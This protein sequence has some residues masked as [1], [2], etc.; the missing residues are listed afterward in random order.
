MGLEALLSS[1]VQESCAHL[2]LADELLRSI[3]EPFSEWSEA[4]RGRIR[5]SRA[6]IEGH[7][8]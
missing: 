8:T 3:A 2:Q 1:A 4:H 5:S 7:L 6:I